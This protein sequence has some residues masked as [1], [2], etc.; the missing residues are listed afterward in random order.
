MSND[1]TPYQKLSRSEFST[2]KQ[3][4]ELYIL[5]MENK[6]KF[7]YKKAED[8]PYEKSKYSNDKSYYRQYTHV[9]TILI[10][11]KEPFARTVRSS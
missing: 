9:F 7:F 10:K 1:Y 11:N 6:I 4:E 3:L 8:F 5:A 2:Y